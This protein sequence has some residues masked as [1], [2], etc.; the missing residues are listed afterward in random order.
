MKAAQ[1]VGRK[2]FEFI[3]VDMPRIKEGE[4]L[5]KLERMSICGSDIRH[6]YGPRYPEEDY[7][8]AVGRPCHECAGVVVR[9][10][11]DAFHEGQRVI[12]LPGADMGGL[13]EYLVS[14]PGR[15]IAVPDD[16]DLTEWIMCQPSGTVLYS[17]QRMGSVLGKSVLIM[18]QGA[19]GLSFTML[20]AMQG[21]RQVI[22]VDLLDYRLQWAKEFGATHTINPGTQNLAEAVAELTGGVGPD[23]TVEAAGYPETLDAVFRLVRQFGTVVVFGIQGDDIVPVD[24]R[25]WMN[26]QPT[27][28]PTTGARTGDPT[29]HIKQMVALKARGQV[30]PGRMVTHRLRFNAADVNQ[31][32]QM[33]EEHLDHVIKVVMSVEA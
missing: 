6:G 3:E 26:R 20:T 7:P 32:Y 11:T 17:C 19:I 29:T 4:C 5:I 15:M 12:V 24:T 16:G 28:I 13:T 33:Y 10:Q 27:I 31:A 22:A 8:L 25:H 9:S 14:S 23:V 1:L 18:G 21:A 30:D 2:L